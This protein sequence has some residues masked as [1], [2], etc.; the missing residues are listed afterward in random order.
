MDPYITLI[1]L[2]L[3]VILSYFFNIVAK[4]IRVP[5]V[6]LLILTGVLIKYG[7]DWLS[8][9][10][11]T[12]FD[13]ERIY[14]RNLLTTLGQV[15]IIMIV[16]EG[17]LD[18]TLRKRKRKL[19]TSSFLAAL[20]IL[21]ISTLAIAYVIQY[22]HEAT[23]VQGIAYAIP[24]SVMSSAI[25]IPSVGGLDEEKKE[26]MV[27][28]STL[29]DIL[30]IMFFNFLVVSKSDDSFGTIAANISV[31]LLVTLL[32]STLFSYGLVY[33]FQRIKTD[34]KLFLII[35]I[36]TLM[37]AVG[38]MLHYS[39]LVIIFL[40]GLILNNIPVFFRGRYLKSLIKQSD[41]RP[42][43]RDFKTVTIESAFLVRTLFFVVFGL[44]ID[45]T[46]LT[47]PRVL[48]IGSLVV[49]IMYFVRLI[50]LVVF[51]K[52]SSIFPE[53]FLSP[54]GL[55][56]I[57]L[58]Y[59]IPEQYQI[60]EFGE[61]IMFFVIIVTGLIMTGGLIF[62]RKQ[63]EGLKD[64][65]LGSNPTSE[66]DLNVNFS[67][68]FPSIPDSEFDIPEFEKGPSGS[69]RQ[70]R[71]EW[72]PQKTA[73]IKIEPDRPDDIESPDPPQ[74]DDP[75]RQTEGREIPDLDDVDHKAAVQRRDQDKPPVQKDEDEKDA[76]DKAAEAEDT[77]T[78]SDSEPDED[79]T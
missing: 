31:D 53:L 17:A 10:G 49:L 30:G 15:G 73:D 1:S 4:K 63:T 72:D 27:Y 59:I 71:E 23:F 20:S 66:F 60:P 45:L 2:S 54:R 50:N 39:S 69:D 62:A 46:V 12:S 18:L 76:E 44:S 38:K 68:S 56:T 67:N 37:Y 58:Y 42:I 79:K 57:L 14:S 55:V 28:E 16:L 22:F 32:I 77:G 3:L 78:S 48:L 61:G 33:V 52:A 35:S 13:P 47:D 70:N 64:F 41:A 11:I 75:L 7:V 6:L 29:S 65:E 51:H 43:I 19:I 5:S 36:L 74:T 40:F 25:V 24:L 8:A 21:I 26:F 34:I 9:V